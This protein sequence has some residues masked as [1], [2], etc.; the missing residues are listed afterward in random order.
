MR[1]TK[2][3]TMRIIGIGSIVVALACSVAGCSTASGDPAAATADTTAVAPP[4]PFA[5]PWAELLAITYS[6]VT[7]VERE[8]LADGVIDELEYSYFQDRMIS[9][10]DDL[11]VTASF[12]DGSTLDY[13]NPD[14]VD[15]AL[16][17]GCLADNGIKLLTAQDAMDRNPENLDEATIMVEC[18]Q[19]VGL[20]GP[21]YTPSDYESSV[22]MASI[23]DD[24]DFEGCVAEPLDYDGA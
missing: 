11:G 24:A 4:T 18:L 15:E 19:R 16:I 14:A 13:S 21:E 8:A 3:G 2:E 5:G 23:A 10:L 20:V 6:D 7:P 9:C 17:D 12:S 1:R 22:D